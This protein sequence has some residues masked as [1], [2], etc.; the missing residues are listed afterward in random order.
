MPGASGVGAPPAQEEMEAS[1]SRLAQRGLV[2]RV[3]A[4]LG[5]P[6]TIDML[7]NKA[8]V[9]AVGASPDRNGLPSSPEALKLK[10]LSACRRGSYATVQSGIR[11]GWAPVNACDAVGYTALMRCC[12]SGQ[13][14]HPTPCRPTLRHPTPRL[15]RPACHALSYALSQALSDQR[16]V[17]GQMLE[18]LLGCSA[19]DVNAT[20]APDGT[21][22]LMLA[23]R[24]RTARTVEAL[25][26]A[27]ARGGRDARGSSE[28]HKAAANPN[29]SVLQ[30]MLTHAYPFNR[31]L[32]L[33][34]NP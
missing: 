8:G 30:L 15:P 9:L 4:A 26:H 3:E 24:Y 21:T 6:P 18:L 23:A 29:E 11:E 13:A 14:R 2:A 22:P 17:P 19:V 12:V 32:T 33:G 7:L 5:G 10:W 16:L 27:G 25:L 31:A 28:L 1:T 34:P 20:G